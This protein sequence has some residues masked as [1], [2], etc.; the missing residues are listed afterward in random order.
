[1]KTLSRN[2]GDEV[3]EDAEAKSTRL[4]P[5]LLLGHLLLPPSPLGSGHLLPPPS[6]LVLGH[7]FSSTPSY[8]SFGVSPSL[9]A[10]L[11]FRGI[12]LPLPLHP[13]F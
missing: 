6:P 2:E 13:S 4:P 9:L 7:L 3:H 5:P 11:P 1:M 12:L 8:F 10:F